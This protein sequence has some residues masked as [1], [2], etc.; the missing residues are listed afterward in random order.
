[1]GAFG[2]PAVIPALRSEKLA[3]EPQPTKATTN[4]RKMTDAMNCFMDFSPYL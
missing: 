2:V 1:V 3:V 4:N